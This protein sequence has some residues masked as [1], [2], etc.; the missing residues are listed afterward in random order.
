MSEPYDHSKD[1]VL[2]WDV[3]IRWP[4]VGPTLQYCALYAPGQEALYPVPLMQVKDRSS[5]GVYP[6]HN[7]ILQ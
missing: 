5:R 1:I 4:S 3:R 7:L 2:N 6:T